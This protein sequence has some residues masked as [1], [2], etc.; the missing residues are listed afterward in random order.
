M[1]SRALAALAAAFALSLVAV[2]AWAP[3]AVHTAAE[4]LLLGSR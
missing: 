3:L 4:A 1:T 2:A